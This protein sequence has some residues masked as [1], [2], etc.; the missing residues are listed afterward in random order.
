MRIKATHLHALLHVK[1]VIE[2]KKAIWTAGVI[3]PGTR[4]CARRLRGGKWGTSHLKTGDVM[5]PFQCFNRLYLFYEF[6]C[7]K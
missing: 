3:G 5:S 6:R 4:L 2:Q 1:K 7:R